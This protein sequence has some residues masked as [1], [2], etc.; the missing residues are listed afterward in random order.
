MKKP[1]SSSRREIAPA[2]PREIIGSS[3][4]KYNVSTPDRADLLPQIN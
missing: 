3:L 1:R 2:R 4:S